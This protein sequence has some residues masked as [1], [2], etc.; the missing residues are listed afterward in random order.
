MAREAC[1]MS[2]SGRNYLFSKAD[3]DFFEQEQPLYYFTTA[4]PL[5]EVGMDPSG[6]GRQSS[7]TIVSRVVIQGKE[8]VSVCVCQYVY[9]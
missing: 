1:G 2:I 8:V 4:V 7:Y 3:V 9:R 6:G 5:V